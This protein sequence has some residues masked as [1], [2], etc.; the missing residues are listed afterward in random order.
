MNTADI[1]KTQAHAHEP[2]SRPAGL[3]QS[4]SDA[5]AT[6]LRTGASVRMRCILLFHSGETNIR[7]HRLGYTTPWG[8]SWNGRGTSRDSSTGGC[9][10][11]RATGDTSDSSSS[12]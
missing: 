3:S 12:P 7:P 5:V 11:A 9:D 4:A 8:S 1:E 2:S 6:E 10:Y